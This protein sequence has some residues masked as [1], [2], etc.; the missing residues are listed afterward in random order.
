MARKAIAAICGIVDRSPVDVH[1][2]HANARGVAQNVIRVQFDDG[3]RVDGQRAEDRARASANVERECAAI[4]RGSAA[5]GV[6]IGERQRSGAELRQAA[7]AADGVVER[8]V[9]AVGVQAGDLI[10]VGNADLAG[11]VLGV[12]AGPSKRAAA[13]GDGAA[14]NAAVDET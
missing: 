11:E 4:D 6:V 3:T 5:I 8:D 12:A 10:A 1:R 13:E 7:A 2:G 9:V 14:A